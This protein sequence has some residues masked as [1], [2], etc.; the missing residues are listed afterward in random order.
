MWQDVGTVDQ[1]AADLAMQRSD[2]TLN[3]D[4][5]DGEMRATATKTGVIYAQLNPPP[6][7]VYDGD[8]VRGHKPTKAGLV[9]RAVAEFDSNHA[10][11]HRIETTPAM[12]SE[13]SDAIEYGLRTRR[14]GI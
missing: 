14:S 4:D 12:V 2:T 1:T 10:L 9:D 8:N 13:C 3:V 5:P 6:V 11:G 7:G